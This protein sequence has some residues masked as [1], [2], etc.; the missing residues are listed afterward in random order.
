MCIRDSI[1]I[2]RQNIEGGMPVDIF[3][4]AEEGVVDEKGY[5]ALEE[6]SLH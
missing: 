2:L 3:Y 4:L 1:F 5:P 6:L